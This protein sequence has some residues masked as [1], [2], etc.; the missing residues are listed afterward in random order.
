[1]FTIHLITL[2][3]EVCELYCRTSIVGRAVK[4]GTVAFQ[5]YNPIDYAE[6]DGG[7][8]D[9]RAYGGGP[10]MVLEAFPVL[11]A[12]AAACGRKKSVH[13]IFLTPSGTI[14][15]QKKAREYAVK[16]K[17]LVIIAGH[18]E[19]ID[20]R[21]V[22]ATGAERVSIGS[23]T[24]TGGE[25]PALAI[26]DATIREIPGVLGNCESLES[27]RVSS[28]RVYTRPESIQW[29]GKTYKVP[30]VLLSGS[31]KAIDQFRKESYF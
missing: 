1:M 11:R 24:L 14:F 31:H 2:F 16:T 23:Y 15:T 12:H 9:R 19:G 17:H 18:Y 7:R 3:P 10:G 25:L 30:K 6:R 27:N 29:K 8:I 4:S 5:F 21:V 22:E 26:A 28:D 20:D 13:T